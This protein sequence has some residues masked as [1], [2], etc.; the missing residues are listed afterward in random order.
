MPLSDDDKDWI[1]KQL[2]G[3]LHPATDPND[4]DPSQL[5]TYRNWGELELGLRALRR[6]VS[7][8][9]NLLKDRPP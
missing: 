1:A 2:Q 7:A 6:R 5:E 4:A 9:E 8:L 3:A